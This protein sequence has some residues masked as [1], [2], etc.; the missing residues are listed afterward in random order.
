[1]PFTSTV[2]PG[3]DR[4]N[5]FPD[6]EAESEAMNKKIF[7]P[8]FLTFAITSI[9]VLSISTTVF[10]QGISTQDQIRF[11]RPVLGKISSI[12]T[13]QFTIEKRDGSQLI[14][15]VDDRTRYRGSNRSVLSFPDLQV[16]RWVAMAGARR[17]AEI[18]LARLVILFPEGFDPSQVDILR[19]R[20]TEILTNAFTLDTQEGEQIVNVGSD[21]AY[22]GQ[23]A[24]FSDL[25]E[26]M[27][28]GV[29]ADEVGGEAVVAKILRAGYPGRRSAGE[30]LVVNPSANT[31]T[32]KTVRNGEEL[33]FSTD[34]ATRFRSKDDKLSTLSD[35]KSGMFALV[36]SKYQALQG[37]D[38]PIPA[39][40]IAVVD[41]DALPKIDRRFVGRI[42]SLG[43]NEFTI[44]N[45]QGEKINFQITG[46]TYFRIGIRSRA[47]FD[48]L[49]EGMRVL[50]GA[51]E[52]GDNSY[53][54]QVVVILPRR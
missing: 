29:V 27:L 23:V 20:I 14:V 52:L 1:L 33:V 2:Y 8:I 7:L 31:F 12:G 30:I 10:A 35:L 46:S 34:T 25:E 41:K 40:G 6:E 53:Q 44:E 36:F 48:N 4:V 50:V 15:K 47:A 19:G 32:L 11:P 51:K 43:N 54:A 49:K 24:G 18:T 28:A 21:T 17:S 45:L 5:I 3:N 22:R 26:G 16:G 39:L 37:S 9:A 13:T 38:E 42:T